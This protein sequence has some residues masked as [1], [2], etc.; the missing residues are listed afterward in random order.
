MKCPLVLLC[1]SSARVRRVS[2][3]LRAEG[4]GECDIDVINTTCNKQD[5]LLCI[6][7]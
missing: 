5:Y 1:M 7:G 4:E 3:R 6:A 2:G